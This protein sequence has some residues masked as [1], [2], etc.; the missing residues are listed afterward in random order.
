VIQG[1]SLQ[2]DPTKLAGI[3][4]SRQG[5]KYVDKAAANDVLN[6]AEKQDLK[7]SPFVK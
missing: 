6:S 5:K 3:F 4:F 1:F 2:L 7:E